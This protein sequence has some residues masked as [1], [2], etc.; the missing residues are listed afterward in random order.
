[1][2]ELNCKFFALLGIISFLLIAFLFSSN[3]K[4]ISLK[5]VIS[6]LIMQFG[7]AFLILKTDLGRRFFEAIATVFS[8][9]YGFA[10]SGA[11]FIFGNLVNM[12]G[13]WGVIFFIKVVPIIIF[14]GALTSLLFHIGAIQFLVKWLSFLLQPIFGTSG[15]ETLC[16]VSNSMLSQTEAPLLIK[17][18]LKNMGESEILLVMISGMSTLSGAIIAVYGAIGVSVIH[19]IAASIMSIPGAILIS[20]ILVPKINDAEKIG[21][22]ISVDSENRSANIFDAITSGTIDGMKVAAC[23]VAVLISFVSLIEMVNFLI[24]FFSGYLF[25][26]TY[27]LNSLFEYLFSTITFLLGI[28]IQDRFAAGSL[29]GQKLVINEFIAYSNFVKMSLDYKTKIILTYALCGFANFSSIGIQ[30]GGIGALAPN[31]KGRLAQLGLKAVLGSTLVN[32]LNAA[33]VS[34][35]IY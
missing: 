10:D 30:I 20:K 27:T 21:D 11:S 1:M 16:A 18:Y 34:L 25:G 32:F 26:V 6:A 31:Q 9:L 23:V 24:E 8:G 17:S 5:L 2:Y 4:S 22:D 35:L 19:L 3:R 14:F 13:P 7:L 28:S 12:N 15:A 29:V 33:I